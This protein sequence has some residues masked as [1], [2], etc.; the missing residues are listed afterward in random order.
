MTLTSTGAAATATVAGAPYG[1]V[2]SGP[3]GT[4]L[5]NYTITYQT[6]KLSINPMALTI[7]ADN[8]MKAEGVP[9]PTLTFT[10]TGL[11]NGDNLTTQPSL[12]TTAVASSAIGTYSITASGGTASSNYTITLVNGTLTVIVD[13]TVGGYDAA[14]SRFLLIGQ[15]YHRQSSSTDLLYG[16]PGIGLIPLC[17]DWDGNG[18]ETIGLYDPT[19]SVF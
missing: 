13:D 2:A 16:V 8:K 17:G 6:G 7:T 14:S 3:V 19:T 4:G 10:C 1:I 15:Q 9:L 18:T 11:V 5:A 12:A